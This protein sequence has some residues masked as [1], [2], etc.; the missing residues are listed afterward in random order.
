[1]L[2]FFAS[3]NQRKVQFEDRDSEMIK[4]K[5]HKLLDKLCEGV[6]EKEEAIKLALLSSIAGESIFLLG[7]PGV[8]KSLIARKLKYA[9]KDSKSFEY[10]MSRF[11]TPDE[12]FGPVSIKQLKDKDRYTRLV[13]QY[14]PGAQ[15]VF[16]DEIWKAG[17]PIQNA[18][19]TVLNEKLYRNGED[20]IQVDIRGLIS[21]S[22]ELPAKDQGLE[23]LWDRFLVRLL[24]VGI[25]NE[26]LFNE[27]IS[28]TS[29]PYVDNVPN[30]LKITT[31]EYEKWYREIS[32]VQIPSEVF[33][34]IG[35]IRKKITLRN[36][37]QTYD[38]HIVVSDRR[39]KKILR[40]LRTSAYINERNS[41]DFM[42]C[43]LIPHC[44]WNQ[45]GQIDEVWNI[46]KESILHGY[47]RGLNI[48]EIQKGYQNLK[49]E[50]EVEIT[51]EQKVKCR[52]KKIYISPSN[53]KFYKVLR[54]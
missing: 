16:L 31:K 1:M 41:I 12:V 15:I 4:N 49:N 2:V 40:L 13:E 44:I 35:A 36:E 30:E 46:V 25:K 48:Q 8:A 52:E 7:P 23:A 39:W 54:I 51:F 38:N 29:N 37:S 34:L 20:E 24:V 42:D 22:N 10:L 6:Y 53:E 43:F 3:S 19:L 9:Y 28:D 27:M 11:S 21:A 45:V 5:I 18:L 50:V 26:T 32:K 14:L 47:K 33:H 17:P